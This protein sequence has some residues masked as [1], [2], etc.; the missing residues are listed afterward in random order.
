MPLYDM[1][2]SQ[3]RRRIAQ[4][5]DAASFVETG[6]YLGQREAE[7]L[8]A[9]Y[10]VISGRPVFVYAHD[11]ENHKG[12]LSAGQADKLTALMERAAQAGVPAVGIF[13]SDGA[14]LHEGQL[15]VNTLG[16]LLHSA[17]CLRSKAPHYLV[18]TGTAAGFGAVYSQLA[19]FTVLV[20]AGI[21]VGPSSETGLFE[22]AEASAA[23][24]LAD[25]TAETEEEAFAY[26]RSLLALT[27]PAAAGTDSPNRT[28][29]LDDN[30]E[31]VD[32]LLLL[33]LL[34]DGGQFMQTRAGWG[35]LITGFMQL[36]GALLGAV[37]TPERAAAADLRKASRMLRFCA[38]YKI[39]VLT[40]ADIEGFAI[41]EKEEQTGMAAAAAE[42]AEAYAAAPA[43]LTV[44]TGSAAG[45]AG[46]LFGGKGIGAAYVYGWPCAAIGPLPAK[47]GIALSGNLDSTEKNQEKNFLKNEM[48]V[49]AAAQAGIIDQ[50]IE[51]SLTRCYLAAALNTLMRKA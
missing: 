48:D 50:P 44:I 18:L 47:T 24:G 43:L 2:S 17:A 42:L 15:L 38:R 49:L 1:P 22:N 29:P 34:A 35:N 20:K 30:A 36:D 8:V 4:L 19:D 40:L 46:A 3:A 16:K 13:H 23:I 32:P 12:A 41:N 7:G 5:T 10:A 33:P 51:P 39:P 25:F 45:T 26:V 11:H 14:L 9:G 6:G 27:S 21:S 31:S 28:L 37:A